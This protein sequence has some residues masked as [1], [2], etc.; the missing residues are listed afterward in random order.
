VSLVTP[1]DPF[2]RGTVRR[3]WVGS[4]GVPRIFTRRG[5]T[6]ARGASASTPTPRPARPE[7]SCSFPPSLETIG[8][9]TAAPGGGDPCPDRAPGLY[10]FRVVPPS[11]R[12]GALAPGAPAPTKP[13]VFGAGGARDQGNVIPPALGI[14]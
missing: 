11:P 12:E 1:H 5:P 10:F 9:R 8:H 3:G 14:S 2:A 7:G 4:L 13:V 6:R